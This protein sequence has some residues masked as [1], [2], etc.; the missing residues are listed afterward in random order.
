MP[1]CTSWKNLILAPDIN[2]CYF[3]FDKDSCS[4]EINVQ[5]GSITGQMS[6]TKKST[7]EMAELVYTTNLSLVDLNQ[8]LYTKVITIL[9]KYVI[10]NNT[11]EKLLVTQEHLS[12]DFTI[13]DSKSRENFKWLNARASKKIMIKILD[14]K[15]DDPIN[16]W[17]WSSPI[18]LEE[19]GSHNVR[20]SNSRSTNDFI[21]WKIDRRIQN[22][23]IS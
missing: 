18:T 20:N 2:H 19:I 23:S 7:N 3:T 8:A 15:A 10:I 11:D 4:K 21:Y 22:V 17:N 16:E 1:G 14:N 5:G 12:N 9:P 13:I 6:I